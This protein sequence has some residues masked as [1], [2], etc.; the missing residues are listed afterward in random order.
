MGWAKVRGLGQG[1][2][3]GPLREGRSGLHTDEALSL[4]CWGR[5][6]AGA[7]AEHVLRKMSP[8]RECPEEGLGSNRHREE[9]NQTA[10]G[11]RLRAAGSGHR[12]PVKAG[13]AFLPMEFGLLSAVSSAAGKE[14]R[15]SLCLTRWVSVKK[16]QER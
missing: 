3:P 4:P 9:A 5:G 12:G 8:R 6:L 7:T 15:G 11:S 10:D 13:R 2:E 1:P 14:I 16:P